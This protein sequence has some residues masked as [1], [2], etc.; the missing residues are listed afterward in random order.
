MCYI[1]NHAIMNCVIKSSSLFSE[2]NKTKDISGS[3]T[4]AIVMAGI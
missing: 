1:S 4:S 2:K 3:M